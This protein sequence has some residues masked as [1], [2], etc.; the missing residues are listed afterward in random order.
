M[1]EKELLSIPEAAAYFNLGEN[2]IRELTEGEDCP[3]VLWIGSKRMIK[4]K[5][6]S[7]FIDT[8]FSL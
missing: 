6:M 3:Y 1:W 8:S 2:K 4:R 7:A 5:K